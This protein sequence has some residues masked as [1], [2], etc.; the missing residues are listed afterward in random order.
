MPLFQ[1]QMPYSETP[2]ANREQHAKHP[3][4]KNAKRK[5]GKGRAC[6]PLKTR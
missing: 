1:A 2:K 3:G 5:T 6:H 4:W